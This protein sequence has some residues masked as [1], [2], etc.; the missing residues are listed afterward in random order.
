MH[1]NKSRNPWS[2]KRL[3]TLP[4]LN[5]KI[6]VEPASVIDLRPER[7]IAEKVRAYLNKI[8]KQLLEHRLN[9]DRH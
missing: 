3:R 5:L 9:R 6:G 7:H 1:I 4:I 2:S 8:H